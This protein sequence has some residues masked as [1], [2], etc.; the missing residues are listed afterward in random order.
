MAAGEKPL[1]LLCTLLKR[2]KGALWTKFDRGIHYEQFLILLRWTA[3]L[4]TRILEANFSGGACQHRPRNWCVD[5]ASTWASQSRPCFQGNYHFNSPPWRGVNDRHT[6]SHESTDLHS[7]WAH[8][9]SFL[10]YIF[11][12]CLFIF[13]CGKIHIMYNL[14]S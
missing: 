13:N 6:Q 4:K 12:I 5:G 2:N 11:L 14:P 10:I 7:K 1:L 9:L 8:G 3:N